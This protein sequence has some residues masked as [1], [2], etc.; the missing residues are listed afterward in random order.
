MRIVGAD[1]SLANPNVCVICEETPKPANEAVIDTQ[2]SK[3]DDWSQTQG[4]KY[5]CERCSS[6]IANLRG[7][8][9]SNA[10]ALAVQTAAL[11]HTQLANVQARVTQLATSISDF[12]N[13]PGAGDAQ[14]DVAVLTTDS[15]AA[16]AVTEAADTV[17]K[18]YEDVFGA[19]AAVVEKPK[20]AASKDSTVGS[21][22]EA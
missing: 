7:Y 13:S 1:E 11:A 5:V 16:A 22:Q 15:A 19:P 14:A 20:K 8:V 4:Q 10:V 3:F 12:V 6:E 21:K 18:S 9:S 2:R 17:Q